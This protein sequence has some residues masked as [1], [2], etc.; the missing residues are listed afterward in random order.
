VLTA[1]NLS[2]AYRHPM[3]ESAEWLAPAIVEKGT[4]G[5]C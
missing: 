3:I 2:I 1:A 5:P 4:M